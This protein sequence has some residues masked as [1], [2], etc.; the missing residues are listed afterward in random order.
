MRTAT[1]SPADFLSCLL[2]SYVLQSFLVL[3]MLVSTF[4]RWCCMFVLYA[5]VY[6][7]CMFVLYA[8]VY[9]LLLYVFC[10][11]LLQFALSYDVL[12]TLCILSAYFIVCLQMS[13]DLFVLCVTISSESPMLLLTT[14]VN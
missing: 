1:A 8:A 2:V 12:C 4:M 11:N 5:A 14:D 6:V 7:Y 13:V 9:V 10:S 3:C